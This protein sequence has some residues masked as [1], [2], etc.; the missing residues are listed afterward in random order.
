MWGFR[1][2]KVCEIKHTYKRVYSN[3]LCCSEKLRMRTK[4]KYKISA[5]CG[6]NTSIKKK[7]F[8]FQVV[9]PQVDLRLSYRLCIYIFFL[10]FVMFS[11]EGIQLRTTYIT[12]NSEK[13]AALETEN[14]GQLNIYGIIIIGIA[15]K[16][17]FLEPIPICIA[18][19]P[20]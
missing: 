1:K 16:L 7:K 15:V 6:V 14:E 11:L 18:N 3:S 10:R 4:T 12:K 13:A 20:E 5:S 17:I 8:I 2:H 19:Q 9:F